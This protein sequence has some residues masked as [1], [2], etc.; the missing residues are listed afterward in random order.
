MASVPEAI[1]RS[2]GDEMAPDDL[3]RLLRLTP[4]GRDVEGAQVVAFKADYFHSSGRRANEGPESGSRGA[5]AR[6]VVCPQS[7]SG[8]FSP[9]AASQCT[10]ATFPC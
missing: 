5:A 9:A 4:E 3:Q 6:A 8:R 1:D 10:H 7:T 2:I